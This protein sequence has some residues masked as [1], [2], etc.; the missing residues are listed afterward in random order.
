M[1]Y[2]AILGHEL[3][4]IYNFVINLFVKPSVKENTHQHNTLVKPL[5]FRPTGANLTQFEKQSYLQNCL[6]ILLLYIQLYLFADDRES[7]VYTV[8][9]LY[10][11]IENK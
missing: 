11:L 5:N 2:D 9:V 3:T 7:I 4:C 6:N 8:F 1:S 10:E